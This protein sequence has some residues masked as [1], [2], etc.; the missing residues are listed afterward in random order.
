[1][2]FSASDID[3]FFAKV[4]KSPGYG[5][6]GDCWRWTAG[7][8]GTYGAFT[9]HGV[10]ID[11]HRVSYAIANSGEL[12]AGCVVMHRCDER[13]CVNPAHLRLGTYAENTRD[14]RDK[15]RLFKKPVRTVPL[16]DAEI[17]QI[18]DQSNR[19]LS[20]GMLCRL[21][22]L[23]PNALRRILKRAECTT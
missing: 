15:D 19:G 6:Q 8:R 7:S 20:Q 13:L 10:T 21:W 16:T 22:T 14:A 4:D 9:L 23:S 3:R 18:I 5:P 1:M 12:P 2:N 17:A 11:A